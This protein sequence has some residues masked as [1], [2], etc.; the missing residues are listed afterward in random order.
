MFSLQKYGGITKY[1]CNLIKNLPEEN[2]YSLS[3]LFSNNQHLNDDFSF[4]KKMY[5]P[6]SSKSTRVAGRLRKFTYDINEWYSKKIMHSNDYDILHP[7][8]FNPYS[9]RYTKKPYVITVHDLIVF[10]YPELC[11]DNRI[12]YNMTECIKNAGRII[13]ISENT[14]KDLVEILNIPS[15]KIDV[16]YHG[17]SKPAP[18]IVDDNPHGRYI[19]YVGTRTGHKNF[20]L[21][22]NA[23]KHLLTSDR[24]LQLVCIGLPFTEQEMSELTKMGVINNT[25]VLSVDEKT[26]NQLY[27]H[28]LAFVYPTK[29]EGFGMP[30]LEA[31]ANNCPVCLSYAGSL[32][33]VAGKAGIYFNPDDQDSLLEAI[34]KTIYDPAFSRSMICA[35]IEQLKSFSW[36]TCAKQTIQCYQKAL[37]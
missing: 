29:Y 32:P 33:E 7:T 28:T 8:F 37:V 30:V 1:F 31:F 2:S 11:K 17:F 12:K 13:S 14:K 21:L 6:I 35:G 5:L 24:E 16:I 9:I 3:L 4:F 26:L 34:K 25:K 18:A 27:T 36:N 19:L 22:A 23:F 15:D 20:M 10:K